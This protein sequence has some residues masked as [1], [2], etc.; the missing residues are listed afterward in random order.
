[1]KKLLFFM[2]LMF[3]SCLSFLFADD[4]NSTAVV[5]DPALASTNALITQVV[6]V[7]IVAILLIG[8]YY[9]FKKTR[10]SDSFKA[11]LNEFGYDETHFESLVMGA[12]TF[13]EK[14]AETAIGAAVSKNK[15]SID[16]LKEVDPGLINT[17]GAAVQTYV[18]D[19]AVS[20]GKTGW[21]DSDGDGVLDTPPATK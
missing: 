4:A 10:S 19:K 8:S 1:M 14:M 17:Y 11:K 6:M 18:K 16:F 7:I 3:S 9:L 5:P 12:I 13:A 15:H 21:T 2:G 20:I